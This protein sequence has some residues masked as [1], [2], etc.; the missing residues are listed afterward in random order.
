MFE[1]EEDSNILMKVIGFGSLGV[2]TTKYIA[3]KPIQNDT[4]V[5]LDAEYLTDIKSQSLSKN[6][7]I[8]FIIADIENNADVIKATALSKK[9]NKLGIMTVMFIVATPEGFQ[10]KLLT[11]YADCYFVLD[12]QSHQ[13]LFSQIQLTIKTLIEPLIRNGL[14]AIDFCDLISVMKNSGEAIMV[15]HTCIADNNQN[16]ASRAQVAVVDTLL[17]KHFDHG[18][19]YNA[20]SRWINMAANFTFSLEEIEQVNNALTVLCSREDQ[21]RMMS[22]TLKLELGDAFTVSLIAFGVDSSK[23]IMNAS[24]LECLNDEL[25]K[26]T[27]L[28][29]LVNHDFDTLEV[30]NEYLDIPDFMNS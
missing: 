17:D 16:I 5:G 12:N 30:P 13:S 3:R 18:L 29:W 2:K 19:L 9:A 14:M 26:Q 4:H 7:D 23:R 25:E 10:N 8:V 1:L 27:L 28:K 20:Q 22:A 21:S 6:L 24:P 15:S 11:K